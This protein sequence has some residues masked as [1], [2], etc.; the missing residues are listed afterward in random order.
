MRTVLATGTTMVMSTWGQ[1]LHVRIVP[2]TSFLTCILSP[3][4]ACRA[5][6]KRIRDLRISLSRSLKTQS[7]G[8]RS[9]VGLEGDSGRR[10]KN[11]MPINTAIHPS[12][13]YDRI[14]NTSVS[15]KRSLASSQRTRRTHRSSNI[16]SHARQGAC[17]PMAKDRTPA[18]L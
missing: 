2:R 7:R 18:D 16:A 14:R 3:E 1:T 17:R 4:C 12:T 5:S 6:S 8:S 11:R 9:E 10:K 15:I 13:M